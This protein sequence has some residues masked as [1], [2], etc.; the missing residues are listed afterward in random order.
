ML[1]SFI[2]TILLYAVLIGSIR[3]MGK[4][5]VGEM[6]PA[7]FVVTMLLA[8]LAAGPMQEGALPLLSAV[9]P[10]LTVLAAE[11]ALAALSMKSQW[12]SRFL[13]GKPTILIADG[14]IDQRALA[15]NRMSM[16]ELAEQLRE[17]DVFDLGAVKYA[18][19][20]TDGELSVMLYPDR[21]PA[22]AKAQ[23]IVPEAAELPCTIVT[24]GRLNKGNLALSG[25]DRAWLDRELR[26]RRLTVRELFLLTV[27]AQDRVVAIRKE[28]S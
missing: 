7:E 17:K 19:L 21:K 13:C 6:E 12:V 9:I 24:D 25:H 23:G 1:I 14:Q 28:E 10:I 11:L 16:D 5:Q 2:R 27:D 22:T 18:I 26:L 3:L 4:R 15:C 20:E 8:N